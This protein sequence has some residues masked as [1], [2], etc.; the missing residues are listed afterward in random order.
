M[1]TNQDFKYF[2]NKL[3]KIIYYV[4]FDKSL[5]ITSSGTHFNEISDPRENKRK[6]G[7]YV[8]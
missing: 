3:N 1:K 6:V 7:E 2:L 4:S 8:F 5:I